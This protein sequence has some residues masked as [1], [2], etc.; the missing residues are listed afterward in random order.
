[1]LWSAFS[2][3]KFHYLFFSAIDRQYWRNLVV[4]FQISECSHR[5]KF[6]IL[7]RI[8]D[9]EI[10]LI[11]QLCSKA[12]LR[13]IESS[14][15]WS[16]CHGAVITRITQFYYH[17]FLF[18]SLTKGKNLKASFFGKIQLHV[19][20]TN[21]CPSHHHNFEFV[22]FMFHFNIPLVIFAQVKNS[23]RYKRSCLRLVKKLTGKF[24]RVNELYFLIEYKILEGFVWRR[25]ES[26]Q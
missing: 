22:D 19:G 5:K 15:V 10:L 24:M 18:F 6:L 2:L 4:E 16:W 1:M 11:M 12:Y 14:M 17:S 13:H 3:N 25:H 26:A 23:L 9:R 21:P 8:K 7:S 20:Y